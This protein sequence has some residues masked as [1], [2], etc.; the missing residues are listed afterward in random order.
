MKTAVVF[1]SLAPTS[2]C[3]SQQ[4]P[5]ASKSAS[6]IYSPTRSHECPQFLRGWS[7]DPSCFSSSPTRPS[8]AEPTH[9]QSWECKDDC[10]DWFW[11]RPADTP[12]NYLPQQSLLRPSS[13][14]IPC[15]S[16]WCNERGF[17]YGLSFHHELPCGLQPSAMGP[18][19]QYIPQLF[20]SSASEFESRRFGTASG[21]TRW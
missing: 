12:L 8:A 4:I 18:F 13:I 5:E 21:G 11:R 19:E 1:P 17:S 6:A 3:C 15:V 2:Q 9:H 10:L 14:C 7:C 20:I 16:R